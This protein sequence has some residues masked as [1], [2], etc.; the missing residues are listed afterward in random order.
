MELIL[1]LPPMTI[2]DKLANP[3]YACFTSKP[4]LRPYDAIPAKVDL[5]A[6]NVKDGE[7]ARLSAELNFSEYDKADP[8]IL[9]R[10]LWQDAHPGVPVPAPVTGSVL[11]R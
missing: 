8:R 2:H 7:P 11:T 3:M 5:M 4:D 1:G 6:T 9:N 10:L